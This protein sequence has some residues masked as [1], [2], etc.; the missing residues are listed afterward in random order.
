MD[1]AEK[2]TPTAADAIWKA[3]IRKENQLKD[4]FIENFGFL[5]GPPRTFV[6]DQ[7][8][9]LIDEDRPKLEDIMPES[10]K[11]RSSRPSINVLPSPTAYPKTSNALVGWRTGK[12]YLLDKYGRYSRERVSIDHQL[13]WPLDALP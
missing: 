7:L 4:D 9:K 8:D 10:I 11:F 5:L 2:V 3:T 6:S 12:Q 1:G 13:K